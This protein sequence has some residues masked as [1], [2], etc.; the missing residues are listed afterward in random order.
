MKALKILML[1]VIGISFLA[2]CSTDED[3]I[4]PPPE[5][6]LE[7]YINEFM[8]SN[9]AAVTDENGEYDDWFEIYNATSEPVDI[10]GTYVSDDPTDRSKWQIPTSSPT[11]TTIPA[12]GHLVIWCDKQPD[13]GALHADFSLSGGGESISLADSDG[14]TVID[15]L[16][17]EG[18]TTDISYGRTPDGADD[19]Q[20][21]D[22][23]T[24][25]ESNTGAAATF[26]PV[27]SNITTSPEELTE[28]TIITISADVVDPDGDLSTV[29][30]TYGEE[31]T[32]NQTVSMT[33]DGDTYSADIG[34]F[35]NSP[36]Y[37]FITATDDANKT[38]ET[39]TLT[40]EIGYVAPA[41]FIN[42]FMAS[43]E[44]CCPDE[45]S[46]YDD[47]IEI[48]NGS[49][50]SV[51][52]GG[53]YITDTLD[54]LTLWQIPTSDPSLTTIQPEEFLVLW[55]DKETDQGILHVELKL[56]GSGEAVGLVAPDGTTVIDSLTYGE[57]TDDVSY[58]RIPDG[59]DTWEPIY[60]PTPGQANQGG[61]PPIIL[62]INEFMAS[63]ETCCP[64]ENSEYDDWVE[65]YNGGDG[66]VNLAGMYLTDDHYAEG[67]AEWYQ[68][69]DS[70]PDLTTVEPGGFLLFWFDKQSE[71]QGV[72][73][74][75]QKLGGSGDEI[76]LIDADAVT[77]LDS[78]IY[79]EQ[80]TD[81]SFGRSPDGSDNWES[82]TAP[83]PGESNQ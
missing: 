10:G 3:T 32:V 75:N 58:G 28:T 5:S 54:E 34:P 7:L 33:P 23:A 40:I 72:M 21:F 30:L 83:T 51:D 16:T 47:W 20:Y 12:G 8:A 49:A 43:N 73:H 74:V 35:A 11:E 4:G 44:T 46:E 71:E 53:M 17:Y 19:W 61:E 67:L 57:Q 24:P 78:Y 15:D 6:S 37:Y 25:G 42:E 82:M 79:T 1:L 66:T 26:P 56:S 81:I 22:P 14:I 27:I 55:A 39:A 65:I 50:V 63:N 36:I 70:D 13:Q 41:L 60:T 62:Y 29:I 68:I 45:N 2:G 18:Q 80:E 48:Y 52:I 64:D 59:S 77:L 31:G 69:P 76:Y 38:A 9:D